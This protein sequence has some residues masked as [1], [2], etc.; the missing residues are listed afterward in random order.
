VQAVSDQTV[1]HITGYG[2]GSFW[3]DA[4]TQLGS[5]SPSNST[6]LG[7]ATPEGKVL[8]TFT[9][10]SANSSPSI[11]DGYGTMVR[12]YGQWTMQ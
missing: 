4:V 1:F 3:G 2:D 9:T 7:S 12:K 5:S 8:L 11:A 10:T 6:M